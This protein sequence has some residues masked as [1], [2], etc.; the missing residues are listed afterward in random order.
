M[1]TQADTTRSLTHVVTT[2]MSSVRRTAPAVRWVSRAG[3]VSLLAGIA[4]LVAG[5]ILGWI[6]PTIMGAAL[7]LLMVGAAA[8]AIGRHPY[9]VGLRLHSGRIVVGERAMGALDITNTS[10]RPVLPARVELPVGAGA[11]SFSLPTLAGGA[12]HSELFTIPTQRRGVI[13]VGPVSSVRG[14]PIGLV[15]RSVVWTEPQELLVHPATVRM[16][17]SAAGF[18][19]DLEGQATKD[20][21][22]ADLAFHAL[23][24]YVPGDDR[25]YVHWRSSAR[26]GTLMVRQF[27]STR[28]T[29]LVLAVSTDRRDYETGDELE[30][31]ISAIGSL[32]LHAF[33][34]EKDVTTLT[35]EEHV[36]TVGVRPFLDGLTRIEMSG[37]TRHIVEL[38]RAIS[39]EAPH[40]TIAVLAVGAATS[41]RDIRAAGAVLP[42]GVSGV[43][44]RAELGATT[45]IRRLGVMTVLTL[46]SLSDLPAGFRKVERRSAA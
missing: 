19:H 43:V 9:E 37:R 4:L 15:R 12:T 23:R 17:G 11:A 13:V 41:A 21:T 46:G 25:R 40:A 36:S 39:Q 7:V 10:D 27:E 6:E 1:N 26:T 28:R 14:D 34:G 30:L 29:H 2:L 31:S 24:E 18:L 44:I 3:W 42:V 5:R 22:N 35:S 38:A 45:S 8:F 32:G 33:A 16:H 20:L